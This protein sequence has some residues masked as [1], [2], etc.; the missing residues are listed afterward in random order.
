M[1]F[2]IGLFT[3]L[4]P[5]ILYYGYNVDL[6]SSLGIGFILRNLFNLI[7]K[8]ITEVTFFGILRILWFSWCLGFLI[9]SIR[10][11]IATERENRKTRNEIRLWDDMDINKFPKKIKSPWS[12]NY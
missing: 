6:L 7:E 11:D 5:I 2:L 12:T 4:L 9:I 10:F 3:H 1:H 8:Y